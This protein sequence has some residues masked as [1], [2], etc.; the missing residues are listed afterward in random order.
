MEEKA[1]L[2]LG[3]PGAGKSTLI[4]KLLNQESATVGHSLFED[5]TEK[6]KRYPLPGCYP[7]VDLIDTPGIL[8][9]NFKT[10][11]TESIQSQFPD[12]KFLAVLVIDARQTRL[13]QTIDVFSNCLH[14]LLKTNTF[15]VLWSFS[16]DVAPKLR[17]DHG[18]EFEKK[19]PESRQFYDDNNDNIN[20]LRR[21][22]VSPDA[23][24][25]KLVAKVK[26]ERKAAADAMKGKSQRSAAAIPRPAPTQDRLG[27]SKC[28]N[29]LEAFK[30]GSS[31]AP[32]SLS[33]DI[34]KLL[35][36]KKDQEIGIQNMKKLGDAYLKALV[37]EL[38]SKQR[39]TELENVG[40][41]Y[42][43]NDGP[44]LM[45]YNQ[46]IAK[47]HDQEFPLEVNSTSHAKTDV[48]ESLFDYCRV[49]DPLVAKFI[50]IKLFKYQGNP[51]A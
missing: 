17:E 15:Y 1:V 33:S 13:N 48:V 24:F 39:C 21:L 25:K 49:K 43:S 42:L 23:P 7:A 45:F 29:S 14:D 9:K 2:F 31:T 26:N 28:M 40:Q 47:K 12:K 16:S 38:L 11:V 32:T 19:F 46:Y 36:I 18:D 34:D 10:N 35:A 37:Y 5:G 30:K 27:F 8:S 41:T 4:N 51:L 22:L 44:M 3:A 50:I 6:V 20:S